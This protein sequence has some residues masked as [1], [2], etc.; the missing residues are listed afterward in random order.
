[1]VS[2]LY[3]NCLKQA[4]NVEKIEYIPHLNDIIQNDIYHKDL[5]SYSFYDIKK[6]NDTLDHKEDLNI[7]TS[8]LVF[9]IEKYLL[10]NRI[11]RQVYETPQVAFMLISMMFFVNDNKE[12]RLDKV[13]EFYNYLKEYKINLPTP[14]LSSF[15]SKYNKQYSSC[16]L[17]KVGDSID[18]ISESVKAVL[19]YATNKVGL[20]ID[21]SDIRG[22]NQPIRKSDA[23]HTGLVPYIKMFEAAL[24]SASQGS[25]RKGS[26]TV[27]YPFWHMEFENLIELKN[28][29]GTSETRARNFD[30]GVLI[31]RFFLDKAIKKEDILLFSPEEVPELKVAFNNSKGDSELFYKTYELC[32]N[33]EG[34]KKVRINAYNMLVKILQERIATGR[35]YIGFIDN[36]NKGSSFNI[37]LYQSNLCME[38]TLPTEPIT[39]NGDGLISLCTLASMNWGKFKD[40]SELQKPIMLLVEA[41]NNLL[42][43][44][45]YLM[46]QAK[47]STDLYRPLGIG[48]TNFAYWLAKKGYNYSSNDSLEELHEW[49]E[50]QYYY[51]IKASVEIAKQKG[52]CD[53]IKDCIYKKGELVFDHMS[54]L[55]IHKDFK[56][57]QNWTELRKEMIQYGVRNTTTSAL[58]PV[59]SSSVISESTNGIEPVRNIHTYKTSKS[60]KI[61][62]TVPEADKL[63]NKYELLWSMYDPSGYLNIVSTFQKFTDQ[64]ISTNT[65][66][67]PKFYDD[68]QIKMSKLI[69]DIVYCY[70]NN[71]KT[72]YYNF[73]NDMAK[74]DY[75]KLNPTEVEDSNDCGCIL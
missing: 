49:A 23:Y 69:Q 36:I 19:K 2:E 1:M 29:R 50:A 56:L 44:Q 72:I 12:T 7:S 24:Q 68:N 35:I 46:P 75:E 13:I 25:I 52:V 70:K 62:F 14:I 55:S 28:N 48:V 63:K 6:L 42:E 40:P 41:L 43:M 37:P 57:K 20:G 16:T 60:G 5:L 66:Y 3:T 61:T 17:I 22:L 34:I 65:F 45:T 4:Y 74:E 38:V 51:L 32:Q 26:A 30:Y 58:M 64:S 8:A 39:E 11:T 18:S 15:R 73:I 33:K 47:R 67:N 21:I 54:P 71:I 10:Q 59:E 27:F 31:N 53:G 9:W